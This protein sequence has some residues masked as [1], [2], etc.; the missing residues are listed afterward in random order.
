MNMT[1][2]IPANMRCLL[3][4]LCQRIETHYQE[5][6]VSIIINKDERTIHFIAGPSPLSAKCSIIVDQSSTG[7]RTV[8]FSI[9][10]SFAKQLIHYFLDDQNIE[11]TFPVDRKGQTFIELVDSTDLSIDRFQT[12]ALRRCQCHNVLEEHLIYL[13][14]RQHSPC[15]TVSKA[16]LE[17]IA[18]EANAHL[19][20]EFI[21]LNKEQQHIRIQRQGVVED[22]SLP[23][24]IKLPNSFVFTEE[25]AKQIAQLCKVT[26]SNEIEIAQHGEVIT[27]NTPECSISC[28]LAGVEEFFRKK[29]TPSHLLKYVALNLF[30]FKQE[31]EHCF[32]HYPRIRKENIA[33]LYVANNT[34]AIAVMTEPYEFIHPIHVFEV[35]EKENNSGSLFRFSPRDLEK[36]RIKN[37]LEAQKT[38]LDIIKNSQGQLSLNV[39]YSL[40]DTLPYDTIPLEKDEGYLNKVIAMLASIEQK[41]SIQAP[42]SIEAQGEL[43]H[44]GDENYD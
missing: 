21:E 33:F 7:L 15:T 35:V 40:Q 42:K 16:T 32:K 3:E 11:L 31:I 12:S 1:I 37:S 39:Y 44:F 13:A 17:H 19:P 20:F 22:K 28:S 38:R 2:V 27:L 6:A 36:I 23:R 34:A 4:I 8:N 14:D 24:H 10:G 43:F 9:D 29:P 18:Y 30:A 26:L 41:H 25:T 5:C